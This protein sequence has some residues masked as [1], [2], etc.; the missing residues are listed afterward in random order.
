MEKDLSVGANE[1]VKWELILLYLSEKTQAG[2]KW[3][4]GWNSELL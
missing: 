2:R 1:G 4:L 3:V